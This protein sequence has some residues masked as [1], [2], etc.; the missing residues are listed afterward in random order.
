MNRREAIRTMAGAAIGGAAALAASSHTAARASGPPKPNIIFILA[1]DLGYGDL[2]CFGQQVIQTPRLDRMAREGIRFTDAYAGSTVCAPSRC[3]LMTGKDTGHA[4][5][6]G[7]ARVPLPPE[8]ITVAEC[9]KQ[10][11]Y[12]TGIVGKWGL[13]EPD[14][15]GT[16][17]KRGFDYWFGYLNQAHAHDYYPDYLWENEE[18]VVL[19]GNLGG[20]RGQYSHDLFTEKGLGFIRDH[21]AEPFFLYMAYTLPHANN[22]LGNE[23]GDGMQVPGYGRYARR[24]WPSPQKGHAAMISRLDRDCGRLLDLLG[25][26]GIARDTLVIFTSD[27]GPHKEGGADPAF[28]DS[29]GPLRGYKRDLYEGGIRVPTIVRW[30]GKAPAGSQSDLPW[31]FWDFMPTAC[32]LAGAPCPDGIDGHSILRA[33]SG[34]DAPEHEFMYWEFQSREHM[35]AVRRGQM[36]AVRQGMGRQTEVYD[37]QDDIGEQ[38]DLAADQRDFVKWAEELFASYR[39]DA[40]E[41]PVRD[42]ALEG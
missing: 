9:L 1:D 10:A 7:N 31:A 41:F 2:G 34:G 18:Q 5:I 37:L 22:E 25:R 21:A 26:L 13:G 6:R 14:S 30:L 36:K 16:P 35:Q 17:N 39:T 27:N 15:V 11:G 3:C 38:R 42:P 12:A 8:E 20:N 4:W 23:T 29:S 40:P 24:D 33:F 19:K 28:F 32:E